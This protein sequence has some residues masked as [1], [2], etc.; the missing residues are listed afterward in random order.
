MSCPGYYLLSTGVSRLRFPPLKFYDRRLSRG[1]P[2]LEQMLS[3][4]HERYVRAALRRLILVSEGE[5][6]WE[7]YLAMN[8]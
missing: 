6:L 4:H 3:I 8:L 1:P 5:T 7:K 2:A